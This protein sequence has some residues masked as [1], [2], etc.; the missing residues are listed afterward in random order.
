MADIS[1]NLFGI[2]L[3]NPLIAASGPLTS[4][5]DSLK[6]LEDKGIGAV[7]LKSI[8]E[9][10]LNSESYKAMLDN[11]EYLGHSD[12][13]EVFSSVNREYLLNQYLELLDKAK[14]SLSIPVIAS[15]NC[16][17]P[18][19]WIEYSSRFEAVNP[20]ALELN[21]YPIASDAKQKGDDVD[22]ALFSFAK[23]ARKATKLPLI[24]KMGNNYSSLSYN[25]KKLEE[26]EIDALVLFNRFYR[27]N[28][29]IEKE[30]II[31]TQA[32]SSENE[33][34]HTLR[35]VAL[36]S[37]ELKHL[38]LIANTGINNSSSVIKMLLSGAKA[39]EICTVLLQNGLDVINRMNEELSLWMD[40]KGYNTLDDFIG[41]LAQ[42]N[43]P[44][45]SLWERTQFMKSLMKGY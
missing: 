34:G 32:F 37:G 35:W 1:T 21:Y 30:I 20:D 8:F 29:D 42:E 33:I 10:E 16:I 31:S 13:A 43:I 23:K 7:V 15:I 45:P 39:V 9:E 3:K 19:S 44:D 17:H 12:F 14:K 38:D 2:K 26:L 22:K 11:E 27:P 6:R 28:I 18:E 5:L 24:I 25:I 36:M 4:N 41:K 40:K